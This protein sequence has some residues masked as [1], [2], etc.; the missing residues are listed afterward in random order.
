MIEPECRMGYTYAQLRE[1]L[2]DRL[3]E[4]G[5]WMRGQTMAICDGRKYNSDTNGYEPACDS[6]AHGGIVYPWDLQRF[7][8]G[9]PI[10]D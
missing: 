3:D 4:F 9:A 8:D 1:I 6:R 5:H 2:G 10:I 7:L